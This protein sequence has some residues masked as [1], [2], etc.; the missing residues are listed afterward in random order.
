MRTCQLFFDFLAWLESANLFY[1]LQHFYS[2]QRNLGCGDLQA[3]A[4]IIRQILDG[5]KSPRRDVVLINAAAVLVAAGRADSLADAT[6]MAVKPLD[7]GAARAKL[8]AL[9]EFTNRIA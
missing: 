8:Q 5:K 3:N 2:S 6:P 9:V 7:S 1:R 4:Q